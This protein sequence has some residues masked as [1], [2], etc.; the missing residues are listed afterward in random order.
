MEETKTTGI[1][2][3]ESAAKAIDKAATESGIEAPWYLFLAVKGG[4]CSGLE[5]VLDLRSY[6]TEKPKEDDEKFSSQ[7]IDIR[8]D[9]KSYVIGNLDGTTI[10]YTETL[11]EAGF[12]FLNSAFKS[13]CGC[14]KSYSA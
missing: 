9:F 5:F 14:G 10:D 11:M 12:S 13:K 1:I 8:V 7:N 2:L 4:G 3:T 6:S